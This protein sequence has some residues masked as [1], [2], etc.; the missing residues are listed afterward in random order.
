[1]TTSTDSYRALVERVRLLDG[2][3]FT[4]RE[5]QIVREAAD[6]R[7]FGDEDQVDIA[8]RALALLEAVV[9][10]ARLSSRTGRA[11]ADLL[12][13]IESVGTES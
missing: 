8:K 1:V 4:P 2:S 13:E 3:V 6:A 9:E 10:S 5:A 11:L 7:L 12:C